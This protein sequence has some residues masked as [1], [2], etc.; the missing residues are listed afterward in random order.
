M[1]ATPAQALRWPAEAIWEAVAPAL[2]GF[3]VEVLPE[4]DSTN[5]ELMRRARAGR[6]DPVLLVAEQQIA[7]RGRMGRQWHSG[8][9]R[10]SQTPA[11][12][13]FSL[14]L[15]LAPADWSG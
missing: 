15:N 6:P 14:G 10:G 8:T 2:P 12:L 11:A 7:G 9:V 5:S 13:T 4:L 1:A 3:T